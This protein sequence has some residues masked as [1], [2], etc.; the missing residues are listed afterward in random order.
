MDTARPAHVVVGVIPGQP[1]AV[2][3]EAAVFASRFGG[4]LVC[5]SVDVT[6]QP[7][8]ER[9][10]GNVTS[11][12]YDLDLPRLE[13][14][15]GF[16][17]ALAAHLATVLAGSGVAWSTRALAGDAAEALG[18]LANTLDAAMIVVG[19]RDPGLRGTLHEI[20]EGSVAA[21]L[22]HRQHRPVVVIPI[23]PVPFEETL[24]GASV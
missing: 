19:T 2:V 24:P 4:E 9:A 23:N 18:Q 13:E 6:R 8:S 3:L 20:F 11:V 16:D 12:P 21:H 7:A 15:G 10:D 5:A 17:P 1:D 22:A 14:L